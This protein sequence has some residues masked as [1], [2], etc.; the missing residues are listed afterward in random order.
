MGFKY[1]P[2]TSTFDWVVDYFIKLCD[3]PSSYT[4]AY[5]LLQIN[6]TNDGVDF[7]NAP[8]NIAHIDFD[9]DASPTIQEGRMG[10]NP[11]DGTMDIGMPGGNVNLQ[12][13]QEL[14]VRVK[15]ESGAQINNGQLVYISGA[16][17]NNVLVSLA[18]A[19]NFLES[20]V[21]GMATEDIASNQFGFVTTQ[22][23]VR[24]VDTSGYSAGDVIWLSQ[25][26]GEF[27]S[28]RPTA[29]AFSVFVGYVINSNVNE[30]NVII[31]PTLV[32]RLRGL[33]DV[34]SPTTPNDQDNLKWDATN[35]RWYVSSNSDIAHTNPTG[36][37][38]RTDST[39]TYDSGT[40]TISVSPV[41][42][43]FNYWINGKEYT[44]ASTISQ[45]HADITGGYFLYKDSND[46][47]VLDTSPWDI[48]AS[49]V[50]MTFIYYNSDLSDAF[51]FEERHGS[52]R[53][54]QAHKEFHFNIGTY[55]ESGLAAN[56][57][58]LQPSSPTDTD[59]R[60]SITTGLISDEDIQS[61][62][63]S[64]S[65]GGPYYLFYRTG[66]D[67]NWAW[68]TSTVP[69]TYGTFIQYNEWTGSTW[70]L[71]DIAN[72]N[73][74]NMYV[75]AVPEINGAKQIIT[76]VDQSEHANL[77]EA[78]AAT[79]LSD[80]DQGD[81]PFQEL[82]LLHKFT[83]GAKSSYSL[84]LGR[85]RIESYED[86]RGSNTAIAIRATAAS[87]HNSLA[88][89]Q[90]AQLGIT[91]G[92]IDD[93]SQA[94]TGEKTFSTGII[95]TSIRRET[96][97]KTANYSMISTDYFILV[98]ASS[99]SVD[100]TLPTPAIGKEVII[101]AIDVT[102]TVRILPN[103]AEKIDS[104]ANLTIGEQ[105]KTYTLISD[106]TNWFLI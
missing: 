12:V 17:G 45:S 36:F 104:E 6:A 37:P 26:A 83:F 30:G 75:A 99:S 76:I 61:S 15:N 48:I 86:L 44:Q 55:Y 87:S 8:Q 106:G 98:D 46:N 7:T 35:S 33:S 23:I 69:F 101:K 95:S 50:P 19:D 10:W 100:V 28:T 93:Q 9:L 64:L 63:A 59:N 91:Y 41:G 81:F 89:L 52:D 13:G 74:S 66:A 79:F 47:T 38:N 5:E 84:A 31:R 42:D 97:T 56:S 78:K 58:T 82:A 85:C 80:I 54:L 68:T 25:T 4:N 29:P 11:N 65:A 1:N 24:D 3:T 92:H 67:G 16:S 51:V 57:Y 22:G 21:L 39:I 103:G 88:G 77:L 49:T 71:S 73:Y 2:F 94:I 105:W 96:S 62:I 43:D 14:L 72:N 102:N 90:L 32:P 60:F 20:F 53:N 27:T 18:D 40:R 70:Q 34:Y